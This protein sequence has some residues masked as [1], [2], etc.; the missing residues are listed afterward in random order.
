MA[1][2][3]PHDYYCTQKEDDANTV[4]RLVK[5]SAAALLLESS[6]GRRFDA[7]RYG[8]LRKRNLGSPLPPAGG[9]KGDTRI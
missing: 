4:E 2:Y 9:R 7:I 8:G 6:I 5:K 1:R 3:P